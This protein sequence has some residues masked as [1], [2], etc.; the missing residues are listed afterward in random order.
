MGNSLV[1]RDVFR[2]GRL[3]CPSAEEVARDSFDRVIRMETLPRPEDTGGHLVLVPR[4]AD[5]ETTNPVIKKRNVALLLEWSAVD[6]S[7]KIL[8]VQ[9]IEGDVRKGD[10]SHQKIVEM[11]MHDLIVKSTEAIKQSQEIRQFVE[12]S[13]GK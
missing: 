11:V 1:G 13:P 5:M 6:P 4:F 12:S 3:L 2:T 10:Y 8:W 7:G 9:T